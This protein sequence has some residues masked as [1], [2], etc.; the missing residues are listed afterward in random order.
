M[1]K[2]YLSTE[3]TS[4]LLNISKSTLYS[5]IGKKKIPFIKLEGKLLFAEDDL[6]KWLETKKHSV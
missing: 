6:I 1:E 5:Y 2:N 3:K 4:K